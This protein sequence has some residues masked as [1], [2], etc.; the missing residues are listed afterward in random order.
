MSSNHIYMSSVGVG[1][2]LGISSILERLA[3]AESWLASLS[4]LATIVLAVVT[5]YFKLREE[6]KKK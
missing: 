2:L 1:G 4:Y 6:S 3:G 5:L